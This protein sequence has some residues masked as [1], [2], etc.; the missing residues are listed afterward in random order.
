MIQNSHLND[1]TPKEIKGKANEDHDR[2]MS[3]TLKNWVNEFKLGCTSSKIDPRLG[4]PPL[5][6]NLKMID[7]IPGVVFSD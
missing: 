1:L 4:L 3:N 2:S 5:V 7:D 6:M